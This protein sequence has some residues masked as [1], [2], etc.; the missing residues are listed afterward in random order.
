MV[1]TVARR[2]R[3]GLWHIRGAPSIFGGQNGS[4]KAEV[5]CGI[6][7]ALGFQGVT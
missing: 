7:I 4:A 3:S 1:A 6:R 2:E 5:F